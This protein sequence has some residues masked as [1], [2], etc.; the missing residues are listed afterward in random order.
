MV[1]SNTAKSARAA[2]LLASVLLI[3][4][5]LCLCARIV[6]GAE[7]LGIDQSLWASAVRGMSAG[8]LLYRDVWEQRPPGIY[9]TYLLGFSI[10]GWTPFAVAALD[11]VASAA[12]TILL[13]AIG[14]RL[15]GRLTGA[16]AA[17]LYAALTMPGGLYGYGGFLE[18][19]V[20]ETF[21][22]VCV[23][24]AALCAA[25]LRPGNAT[26]P[27]IGVG[28]FAGA[29]VMFKPNAGL[30]LPA[31]LAWVYLYRIRG[32]GLRLTPIVIAVF[33][34]ALPTVAVV[35]W[36]WR[37]GLIPDAYIAVVEFNR[38]YVAREFT[39]GAF[40]L[41]FSKSVFLRMKT[42]PIW[43]AGTIAS[44]AALWTLVRTRRLPEL[45]AL[46]M[47]WGA[48]TVMVIAV[49]G[50]RLYNSYFLQAF[51][52]LCLMAAWMLA[53]R[54]TATTGR[55][56]LRYSTVG[57]MLLFMFQG[58]Y[59]RKAVRSAVSDAQALRGDIDRLA[60][61]H[62]FGGY[63]NGRGYSA[64]AN[65]ELAIYVAAHT[66]PDDRIF[67]FG[68]NG[69]G[70]YFLANRLGAHRFLRVNFFYPPE[71]DRPGFNVE[72]VTR[73]L[74]ERRPRY[75]I[76]ENL[77]MA[78]GIGRA[79]SGVAHDPHVL[80]LLEEYELEATIEDFTIYRIKG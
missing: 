42:D 32:S 55:R 29:A 40:A 66:S 80:T 10:F 56:L 58:G 39:L 21:I 53:D 68:V 70:V 50:I 24:L 73:D 46:A 15:G 54:D 22:V 9:L 34:S 14:H 52:P 25:Y 61:L 60:Y 71:F 28:L 78:S 7:P 51:A 5:A 48:A 62:D 1:T 67:L 41:A 11:I 8:Q 30:Y 2:R 4:A 6:S 45:P 37:L 19:A 69:A 17:A 16:V 49:N 79:V 33:A 23:G 36:L 31:V 44:V 72:A 26:M 76:F 57:L 77:H 65:E 74:A 12:T 13:W 18:R 3:V 20:S 59:V 75:V 43:V 38:A 27:A 47:F 64:R 35:A 63:A